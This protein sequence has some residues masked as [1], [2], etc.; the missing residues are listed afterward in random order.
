MPAAIQYTL[1]ELAERLGCQLRGD[2]ALI[3]T[4]IGSLESAVNGQISFLANRKFRALLD[5]TAAS[6]VIVHP[7]FAEV[8]TKSCLVTEQPY[9]AFARA[10]HLFD[11]AA[12]LP[13]QVFIPVR[14]CRHW[15]MLQNPRR[16]VRFVWWKTAR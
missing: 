3:V 13:L 4:G 2:G 1:G 9:L 8:V 10:T 14:V 7:E 6:A 16:S 12:P 5:A 15:L 11:P